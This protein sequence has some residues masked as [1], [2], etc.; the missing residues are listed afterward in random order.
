[1]RLS[2]NNKINV[3]WSWKKIKI[4][5]KSVLI[6]ENKNRYDYYVY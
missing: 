1:M 2:N 5:I 4:S 6:I 3:K